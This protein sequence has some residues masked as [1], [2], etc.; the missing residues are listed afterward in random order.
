MNLIFKNLSMRTVAIC[1]MMLAALEMSACGKSKNE[2]TNQEPQ[3]KMTKVTEG[4]VTYEMDDMRVTWLQDL[5]SAQKAEIF[6]ADPKLIDSLGLNDGVPSSIS[7]FLLEIEGKKILFDTGIGGKG[8]R[9]VSLL[10]SIGVKPEDVDYLYLTHF[11]GDH[12]GGMLSNGEPVFKNSQIYASQKEYD[13]WLPINNKNAQ[14]IRKTLKAYEGRVHLF[15]FGDTLP[16]GVM[17]IDAV[18][19]TPGHTVYQIG[20]LLV[21]GDIMHGTALQLADLNICPI[22]D[23]DKKEAIASHRRIL[24]YAKDNDLLMAGM[25]FPAPAFMET[26]NLQWGN[27]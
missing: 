7:A 26:K 5:A 3:P 24:Q 9:I 8:G 10:D 23:M 19:H 2:N 27:F 11:H 17:T 4:V 15:E 13:G 25:H 12:I 18:G 6:D 21:V 22:Y 1:L 14:L 16:C 20:R